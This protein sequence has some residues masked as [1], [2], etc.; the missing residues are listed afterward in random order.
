MT[1]AIAVVTAATTIINSL[2]TAL[3][4]LKQSIRSKSDR[5]AVEEIQNLTIGLQSRILEL[6]QTA[7]ELQAQN[8]ELSEK[9]G[10]YESR[11]LEREKYERRQLGRSWVMVPKGETTAYVCPT[12]FESGSIVFLSPL[13]LPARRLELG[14][15]S[16]SSCNG[17]FG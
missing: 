12:C 14:T 5:E 2:S 10:T 7:F 3:N 16:C 17:R 11:S 8:R 4:N 6:Q 13:P 1:D 9:L 15:H